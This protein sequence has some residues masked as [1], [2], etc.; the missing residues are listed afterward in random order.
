MPP[1]QPVDATTIDLLER[2]TPPDFRLR[3]VTGYASRE[4]VLRRSVECAENPPDLAV[5]PMDLRPG[6]LLRWLLPRSVQ[7]STPW[8]GFDKVD[9]ARLV[10]AAD[11]LTTLSSNWLPK[12]LMHAGR[13]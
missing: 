11:S 2:A 8:S 7:L 13:G 5:L 9:L 3:F 1:D 4:T 12:E 10:E 6:N